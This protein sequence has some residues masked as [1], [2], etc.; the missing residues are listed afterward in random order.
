M[1]RTTLY[2][3]RHG[4]VYNPKDVLYA[5]LPRF[6][7]SERGVQEAETTARYLKR[8]PIKALYSSPM[9]RARQTA[10][11]LQNYHP[12]APVHITR[13][14]IE[15]KTSYQ[16]EPRAVLQSI[17]WNFY[18]NRRHP[19]DEGRE[20]IL[21]RMLKELSLTRRRHSGQDVVWVAHGDPVII[22]TLWGQGRPLTD[23]HQYKGHTYIGHASVTA[24]TFEPGRELPVQVEYTDPNAK[25]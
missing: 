1:K 23:L 20:D 5:R 8:K 10:K 2:F 14:L 22:L 19:G 24:F 16:G 13:R 7:L 11:I 9:L 3:V 21:N 25:A 15:V 18:D 4:E 6:R 17:G 12:Q